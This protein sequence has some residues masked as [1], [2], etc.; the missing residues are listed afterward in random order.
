MTKRKRSHIYRMLF[1]SC[2]SI[3]IMKL[4]FVLTIIRIIIQ[5]KLKMS[6][7]INRHNWL[8][9]VVMI[10]LSIIFRISLKYSRILLIIIYLL[11]N[12]LITKLL[13]C[14]LHIFKFQSIN[15]IKISIKINKLIYLN[16]KTTIIMIIFVITWINKIINN[17]LLF[18]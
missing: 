6:R 1:G 2:R 3:I 7:I 4:T 17:K 12:N 16:K 11:L 5:I 18:L 8:I 9:L 10:S 15:K 13:K 14:T